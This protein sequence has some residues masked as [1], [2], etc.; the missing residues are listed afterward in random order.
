MTD[1]LSILDKA[2]QDQPGKLWSG[3]RPHEA[4]EAAA[5][6]RSLEARVSAQPQEPGAYDL[7]AHESVESRANP[8]AAAFAV[9]AAHGRGIL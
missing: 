3:I 9:N 7:V 4:R 5:L 8:L 6:I 1:I 2:G